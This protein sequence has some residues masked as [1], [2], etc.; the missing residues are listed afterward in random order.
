M[1]SWA[2]NASIIASPLARPP[3]P[4][5]LGSVLGSA[6]S[7]TPSVIRCMAL[8]LT[9]F[10]KGSNVFVYEI[11]VRYSNTLSCRC[12]LEIKQELVS[13]MAE[14]QTN[15]KPNDEQAC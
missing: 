7:S 15:P 6:S 1:T 13:V 10:R 3:M 14:Q 5:C 11:Y 4:S 2:A 9:R 12:Q 8:P